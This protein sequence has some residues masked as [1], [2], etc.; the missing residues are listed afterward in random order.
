MQKSAISIMKKMA[1]LLLTA[2]IGFSMAG[3]DGKSKEKPDTTV[4]D[5]KTFYLIKNEANLAWFADTVNRTAGKSTLNAKLTASLSMRHKL[6]VPIAAGKGDTQFGGI[7]D[8]DGFT[9]SDLYIDA[10]KIGEIENPNCEKSKANCNAQNVAFIAAL[11]GGTVKNLILENVDITASTNAGDILSKE[12]PITVGSVVAWQTSGTI[13]GCFATGN[14]QTSGK[15]NV[16]GGIVGNMKGGT[17]KNNLSTVSIHVSGDESYV[18]GAVGVIR[19]SATLQSV[20]YDGN[21][22]VNNGNGAI[23]GVIGYLENGPATVSHTYF[24]SDIV[25][26]G[27]GLTAKDSGKVEL[28]G[29][30]S[31]KK[32]L[33]S[34]EVVCGLNNGNLD[35][36]TCPDGIWNQGATHISLNKTSLNEN[37]KIVYQ[38]T[39]DANKGVFSKSAKTS[40]LLEAGEA[41]TATEITEPVRGDTVFAGW[42]L[43]AD[44]ESPAASLGIAA[45]ATTV[46]AVWKK[47]FK[48]TFDANGGAFLN[49]AGETVT[50]NASKIVAENAEI[51]M[52]GIRI[53]TTYGIDETTFYFVGWATEADAEEPLESLGTATGNATFYA[54]WREEVTYTV[55]FDA[56]IGG[57]SVAFVKEDGK[58]VKPDDPKAEGY[59]FG[60][61]FNGETSYDFDEV[62]T[63]DLTLTSQWKPVEYKITYEL[64]EGKN[65]K[66]NPATYTVETATIALGAPA[67][68]GYSFDGWFYDN[69]YTDRATQITKGSIG[70]MT[71]YAKWEIETFTVTYMAGR[72]GKGIV[73]ADTKEYGF[74]INLSKKTYTREGYKQTGWSTTDGGKLAYK[75]GEKYDKNEGLALFPYWEEDPDAIRG[76]TVAASPKFGTTARG[77]TLEIYGIA[78]GTSLTVF[79][80][81]GRAIHRALAPSAGLSVAI[82]NP[83]IYIVKAG[84]NTARVEIK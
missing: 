82:A 38:I 46:Y 21:S 72:Y 70:D 84:R 31:G 57:Y 55:T 43:T 5:Q 51:N 13:E 53:G 58:A 19:G 79:D 48:I 71:L 65:H 33:N 69:K 28:K 52:E 64:G 36:G 20:A 40:K 39:F 67:K 74:E 24:D 32:D 41:I 68:E 6:F 77:R 47:M 23:G 59:T 2:G 56:G 63:K 35:E 30:T 11:G 18:G 61:W 26:D 25:E 80:M 76:S 27:I 50:G 45:K 22:L 81:N 73:A 34:S 78:P 29:S 8:G 44:A 4:I 37:G 12:Q 14:I 49:E 1:V 42:A 17:I 62:V 3:W 7:F 10:A 54:L 16:V 60:G 9:I 83:G 15:G 75:L 66:D